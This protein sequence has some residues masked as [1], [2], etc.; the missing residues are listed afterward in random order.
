[1]ASAVMK[2]V[3][4]SVVTMAAVLGGISALLAGLNRL[5]VVL[6]PEV[7]HRFKDFPGVLEAE[8]ELG[9]RIWIPAYFPDSLSWPPALVRVEKSEPPVVVLGILR[10]PDHDLALLLL[11]SLGKGDFQPLSVPPV[12]EVVE[13]RRMTV[14]GMS[15]LLSRTVDGSGRIWTRLQWETPSRRFLLIGRASS[16]ELIRMAGS[17]G[18][19]HR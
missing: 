1:M 13:T 7:S 10:N 15:A 8:R 2:E 5:P 16:E 6:Q 14:K 9:A 3:G 18:G 12:N 19:G 11:Q 17:V 4:K